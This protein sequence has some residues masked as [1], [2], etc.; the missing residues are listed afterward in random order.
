MIITMLKLGKILLNGAKAVLNVKNIPVVGEILE[1]R[2]ST[3][4][5][6]GQISQVNLIRLIRKIARIVI[7]LLVAY[8]ILK[9]DDEKAEKI[10]DLGKKINYSV[11]K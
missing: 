5:G 7:I 6:E 11:V 4:G 8:L 2:E 1:E 9:G 3:T 10:Q